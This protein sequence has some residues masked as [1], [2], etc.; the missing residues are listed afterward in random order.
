MLDA[1]ELIEL[2]IIDAMQKIKSALVRIDKGL[3]LCQCYF[4]E[5]NLS[6]IPQ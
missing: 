6:R 1:D 3:I 2:V 4:T 5:N